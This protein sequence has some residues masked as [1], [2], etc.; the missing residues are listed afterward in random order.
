MDSM[1][2][3]DND[4]N[5]YRRRPLAGLIS[6]LWRDS[7]TLL[8]DEAELA[9]AEISEKVS[10]LSTGI[11][12]LAIGGAVL[13]AGFLL[14]LFAIVGLLAQVLPEEQAPWLAPLLV[15]A[16]VLFAGWMLLSAGRHK[17]TAGNLTP[18][19]TVR[20]VQLDAELVKEHIK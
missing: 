14:V 1:S 20:S 4:Y 3:T 19:R 18:S 13:F 11:G 10:Q 7:A 15:G 5:E 9:K 2:P 16:A 6:D 12:S 8:R 17:L